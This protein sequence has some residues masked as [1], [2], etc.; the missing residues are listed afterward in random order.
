[1][2]YLHF[3]KHKRIET[4]E[5]P[6]CGHNE[7]MELMTHITPSP[8]AENLRGTINQLAYHFEEMGKLIRKLNSA[9]D[10]QSLAAM[11]EELRE[12]NAHR[13]TEEIEEIVDRAVETV[14][15]G[16]PHA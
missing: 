13:R 1:M 12:K 16:S 5:C 3:Q 10:T 9:S 4:P 14:R 7:D 15:Y 8:A 6:H 2:E 11:I